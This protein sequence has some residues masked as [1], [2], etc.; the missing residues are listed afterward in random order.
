MTSNVM[1]YSA[2]ELALLPWSDLY[3]ELSGVQIYN[4]NNFFVLLFE[5]LFHRDFPN[6]SL[7]SKMTIHN[8]SNFLFLLTT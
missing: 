3:C 1:Q 8:Y 6:H 4:F 2:V 5:T 7:L